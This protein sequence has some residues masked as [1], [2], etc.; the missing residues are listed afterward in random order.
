MQVNFPVASADLL[1]VENISK[2]ILTEICYFLKVMFLNLYLNAHLSKVFKKERAFSRRDLEY[3]QCLR[4]KNK[5]QVFIIIIIII[6]M[7]VC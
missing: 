1:S 5:S 3:K 2:A 7:T 4:E 6:I